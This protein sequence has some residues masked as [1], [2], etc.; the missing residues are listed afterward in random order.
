[1]PEE[2]FHPNLPGVSR[3]LPSGW[4]RAGW[5]GWDELTDEQQAAHN[6]AVA[7]EEAEK[8]QPEPM[9]AATVP[10]PTKPSKS[11][12]TPGTGDTKKE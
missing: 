12:Q 8:N 1:M 11:R 7:A 10:E 3:T 4:R 6:A 5:V 9:A 2:L